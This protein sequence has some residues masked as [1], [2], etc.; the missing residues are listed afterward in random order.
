MVCDTWR[1]RFMSPQGPN[2]LMS[3]EQIIDLLTRVRSAGYDF[4]KM[5]SL[6]NFDGKPGYSLGQGQ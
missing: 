6:C 3:H 1:C 2:A 4:I 5:E